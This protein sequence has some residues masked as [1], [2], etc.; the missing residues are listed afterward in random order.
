MLCICNE[1][2]TILFF[3]DPEM[4]DERIE[5][6]QKG[7]VNRRKNLGGDSDVYQISTSADIQKL[8]QKVV[9]DLITGTTTS[10]KVRTVVHL[11]KLA[12]QIISDL[13]YEI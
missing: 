12:R 3:H 6:Q 8:L 1:W 9:N 13:E 7:G 5:A 10:R 2:I 4:E 11:C